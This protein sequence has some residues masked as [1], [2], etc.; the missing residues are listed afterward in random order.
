MSTQSFSMD[1]SWLLN[2]DSYKTSHFLQ[3]P[4]GTTGMSAYIESRGGQFD[5][6]V[7]FGL[8]AIL[9]HSIRPITT[10][11]VDEAA[12]LFAAHGEP[13]DRQAFDIIVKEY[14]G[15]P[16]LRILAAREG[17]VIP[18]HNVLA[19]IESTD[20]RVSL[21]SL[22]QYLETLILRVWYPITVA[23]L[24]WHAKKI[25]YKAL[26]ASSDDP[27]GQIPFKLH[28]FGARGV[29]SHESAMLGG[30]AHLVNFMGTDTVAALV[31][32]RRFYGEQMAG[33]S[34]P[35]SEHSTI[36]SWGRDREA[37]AYANMLKQFGQPGRILACVSDSYDLFNAVENIWGGTLRQQ[38]ID[39]GATLV[40]RP[41]S[42]DPV[43]IVG[44]TAELLALKFGATINSKGFKVL[45]NVRIIQGDGINLTTIQAICDALIEKGFSIDNIAFG[46]GGALLQGVNRDTQK[47]AMKCSAACVNGEWIDVYKDPITDSGKRSKRGRQMLYRQ[48]NG[49]YVSAVQGR[50]DLGEEALV[51]VYEN[52]EF[53][54]APT[55]AD[56]RARA[57]AALI[58]DL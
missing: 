17:E 12:E 37:D 13:F 4:A 58:R 45:N 46:M 23:S 6:T 55:F 10:D 8:N 53:Y 56:I 27:D 49:D 42:G 20:E 7:M 33:Y 38:V 39:S 36:T 32:A 1:V 18:T 51:K 25:I 11:D 43:T 15:M 26:Q 14:G 2:T 34:I 40:V 48:A 31:G 35:A 47:M 19:V 22:G 41:D 52:G 5:K 28:D 24:S 57:Q 29:S 50:T 3:F 16:P 30:M 21:F 44:M 54:N 9:K